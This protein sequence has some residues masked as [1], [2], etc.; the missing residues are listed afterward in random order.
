MLTQEKENK[1]QEIE[2][3]LQEKKLYQLEDIDM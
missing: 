2:N 3:L 1:E